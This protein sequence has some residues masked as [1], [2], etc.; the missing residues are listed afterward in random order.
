VHDPLVVYEKP[1]AKVTPAL[2]FATQLGERRRE[3][4]FYFGH[5]AE[6]VPRVIEHRA[7]FLPLF[8]RAD[9]VPCAPTLALGQCAP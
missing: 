4:D 8:G 9:A 6:A 7:K 1:L 5:S 2:R 3:F